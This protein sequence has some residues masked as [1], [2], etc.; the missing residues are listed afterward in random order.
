[1]PKTKPLAAAEDVAAV[2]T[3]KHDELSIQVLRQFR[4]IFSSVRAHFREVEKS[5]GTGGAQV[6]ALSHIRENPGLGVNQLAVALD[7]HQSTASSLVRSLVAK[8][9]VKTEQGKEDRRSVRLLIRP[10]GR[11]LLRKV[12]GP[13]TGVLPK[14]LSSLDAPALRRL[15]R[16]LAVLIETMAPDE[17]AARKPLAQ[18]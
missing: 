6:W 16:D 1:M 12:P 15:R 11:A 14:A 5:T 8:D 13:F 3:S 10:A 7:I 18:M 4:V 9:L 2:I 17:A